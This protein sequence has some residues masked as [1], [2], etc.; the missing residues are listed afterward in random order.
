LRETFKEVSG[1]MIRIGKT[2]GLPAEGLTVQEFRCPMVKA[3]WLQEAGDTLNP[4]DPKAMLHCGSA[5]ANLPKVNGTG[6][7]T[8]PVKKSSGAGVLAVPRS[9][10]IDTGHDKVVF[11]ESAEMEGVFDMRR[12]KVGRLAGEYYPVVEGVK[13]GEKV[14]TVG[15]FLLD[16]ENR[17]NPS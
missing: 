7:A 4:Y 5:V 16:A 14:V 6:P 15:A 10:V 9:A 3:N 8:Q 2:V 13:E 11:V 1:A 17:L 12:V